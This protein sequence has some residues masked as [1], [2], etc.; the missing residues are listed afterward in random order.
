M[1]SVEKLQE[2]MNLADVCLLESDGAKGMSCKVPSKKE[3]VILE[4]T[5]LVIEVLG[6]SSLEKKIAEGC[7]RVEET[8][9][10]LGKNKDEILTV[11]D[12]AKI[13]ASDLAGRKNVGDRDYHVVLNQCDD[14]GYYELAL[15]IKEQLFEAGIT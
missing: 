10:F 4:S 8:C 7:F 13:A 15:K 11:S 9:Q 12:M 2:Y 1:L 6:M 5:D 3:P 14:E